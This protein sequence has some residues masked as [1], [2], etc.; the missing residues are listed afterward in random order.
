MYSWCQ[1]DVLVSVLLA[2]SKVP[3]EL[4]LFFFF[5][6][7]GTELK[8]LHLPDKRSSTELNPQ[9][10]IELVLSAFYWMT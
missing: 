4:V 2:D 10:H 5:Y 6:G 7:D 3:I 1:N 8:A 9:P